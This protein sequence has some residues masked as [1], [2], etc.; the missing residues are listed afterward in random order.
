MAKCGDYEL[1]VNL[2]RDMVP[3]SKAAA[4]LAALIK[5][6]RSERRPVVLTQKG[7]PTAV[8]IDI[9][10]WGMLRKIA[11]KRSDEAVSS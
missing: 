6:S 1:E 11:E 5:R 9:E 8:I 2:G 7:Y 4:A 3:I 10:L